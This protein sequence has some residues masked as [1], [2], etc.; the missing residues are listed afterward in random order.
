MKEEWIKQFEQIE[1][2]T[3]VNE[4]ADLAPIA[5][6]LI[7]PHNRQYVLQGN[8][9]AYYFF[10]GR[11]GKWL[12]QQGDIY[13]FICVHPNSPSDL[14]IFPPISTVNTI[15]TPQKTNALEKLLNCTPPLTE[16]KVE[17]ARLSKENQ[18]PKHLKVSKQKETRLDWQYPVRTIPTESTS[19]PDTLIGKKSKSFRYAW[20]KIYSNYHIELSPLTPNKL[21]QAQNLA[22]NWARSKLN[23]P[24]NA[25]I[26]FE[27]NPYTSCYAKILELALE[28]QC[29]LYG[30][31]LMA[32]ERSSNDYMPVGLSIVELLPSHKIAMQ[33]ANIALPG[34]GHALIKK[35]CDRLYYFGYQHN[36][37][38]GSE[39]EKLDKFKQSFYPYKDA[40]YYQL[41]SSNV[42][43]LIPANNN[44][45]KEQKTTLYTSVTNQNATSYSPS[46]DERKLHPTKMYE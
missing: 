21:Q 4:T 27:T 12:F 43:H 30:F 17:L 10:T 7:Q 45:Q 37:L 33:H 28:H 42:T 24:D 11:N 38:G 14:L 44:K 23:S 5:K 8:T 36:T 18:L 31:L 15:G 39:E 19:Q 34:F 40:I 13:I 1:G 9:P 35:T 22:C 26:D 3:P 6:A 16:G 46:T 2:V 32:K 29:N 25:K 20:N 41:D